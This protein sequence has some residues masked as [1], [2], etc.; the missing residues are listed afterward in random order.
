MSNHLL[1][2]S[3]GLEFKVELTKLQCDM[4]QNGLAP[5]E[6]II[7]DGQSHNYRP[8]NNENKL[9]RYLAVAHPFGKGKDLP[10]LTC[11]YGFINEGGFSYSSLTGKSV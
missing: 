6:D 7:P 3:T 4:A 11:S 2:K 8:I 1:N 10:I 5:I 9:A